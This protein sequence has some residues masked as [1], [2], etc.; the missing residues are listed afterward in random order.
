[1]TVRQVVDVGRRHEIA[2]LE[3]T[4]DFHAIT[5]AVAELQLLGR[6]RVAL[7]TNARLTP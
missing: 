3:A 1:M 2:G 5:A 6:Q 7:D 4:G